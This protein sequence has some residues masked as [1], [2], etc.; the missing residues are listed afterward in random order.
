MNIIEK[1]KEKALK[2]MVL[3]EQEIIQLLEIPLGF[4]LPPCPH[5][6]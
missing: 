5:S 2:G 6:G 4:F 3:T 1:A